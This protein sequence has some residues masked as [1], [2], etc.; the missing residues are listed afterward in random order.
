MDKDSIYDRLII[1]AYT[2]THGELY[3]SFRSLAFHTSYGQLEELFGEEI[4]LG[5]EKTD[6]TVKVI[7]K[8]KDRVTN[9]LQIELCLKHL[10]CP[11]CA[12]DL[13]KACCQIHNKSFWDAYQCKNCNFKTEI[14]KDEPKY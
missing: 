9:K 14:E 5:E 6:D 12:G 13:S 7:Q 3:K 11:E 4:D 8:A 1:H 10:V 2:W